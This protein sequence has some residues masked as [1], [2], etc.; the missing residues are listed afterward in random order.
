MNTPLRRKGYAEVGTARDPAVAA[1][2]V[3]WLLGPDSRAASG[4]AFSLR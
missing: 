1:A 4:Q 3:L 2:G